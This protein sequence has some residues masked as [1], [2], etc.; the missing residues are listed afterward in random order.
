MVCRARAT[1]VGVV[2]AMLAAA[3]TDDRSESRPSETSPSPAT[4]ALDRFELAARPLW[5]GD[6]D[7]LPEITSRATFL[8]DVLLLEQATKPMAA[9]NPATGTP[10]WTADEQLLVGNEAKY[11]DV[12]VTNS[13][14][15][16]PVV[17]M[18]NEWVL[19]VSYVN[20]G[21]SEAETSIAALRLRDASPL[22][23]AP[24]PGP[25]DIVD[26]NDRVVLLLKKPSLDQHMVH[27]ASASNGSTMWE[28]ADIWPHSVAGDRVLGVVSAHPPGVVPYEDS[29]VVG[30]DAA[31]GQRLWSLESRYQRSEIGFVAGDLALV[32]VWP[33]A[34]GPIREAGAARD[35]VVLIDVASGAEIANLGWDFGGRNSCATD[36]HRI[37]CTLDADRNLPM[38]KSARLVTFDVSRRAKHVSPEERQDELS[39][40]FVT[41]VWDDYVF[42]RDTS[43]IRG[44]MWAVDQ[45]GV[46]VSDKLPGTLIG[47]SDEYAVFTPPAGGVAAVYKLGK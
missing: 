41:R 30:L 32:Y 42:V 18:G 27:V 16:A 36:D 17:R 19:F 15:H 31:T 43:V 33:K 1:V 14:G 12:E 29:Y 6:A 21:G 37:A 8:N 9:V 38:G 23:K 2:I 25:F 20:T 10:Y 3:C 13:A 24:P 45:D 34:D 47:I 7:G 4:S 11:G 46:V 44:D 39:E 40:S 5:R 35:S 22:W 28:T 26:A